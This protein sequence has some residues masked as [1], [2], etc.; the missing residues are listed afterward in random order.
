MY[1]KI[2]EKGILPDVPSIEAVLLACC[3]VMWLSICTKGKYIENFL[4]TKN[5]AYLKMFKYTNYESIMCVACKSQLIRS[6]GG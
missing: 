4:P 6:M 1:Y 3:K 5:I 2:I